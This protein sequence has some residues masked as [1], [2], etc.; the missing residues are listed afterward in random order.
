MVAAAVVVAPVAAAAAAVAAVE[1]APHSGQRLG[2]AQRV[3]LAPQKPQ[4]E[5]LEHLLALPQELHRFDFVE[6]LVDV[7]VLMLAFA[8]AFHDFDG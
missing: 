2:P 7:A 6:L 4:Q 1:E 3:E 5:L 8:F